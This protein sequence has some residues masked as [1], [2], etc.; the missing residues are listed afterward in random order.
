MTL[1]ADHEPGRGGEIVEFGRPPRPRWLGALALTCLVVAAITVLVTRTSSHH[2]ATSPPS[3][4]VTHVGHPILGVRAGWQLFGLGHGGLIRVQFASGQIT[5]TV[6]PAPQGDGIE[7]LLA[8]PGEALVRPLDNVTGYVVPDGK[9]ARP[10]SGAL[11]HGGILLPGPSSTQEWLA[12]QTIVLVGPNGRPEDA[13]LPGLTQA[14]QP[15][16][17]VAP[18]GRGGLLLP[19][20]SGA[21]YDVRSGLLRPVSALLLATGPRNWL[22]LSCDQQGS[23]QNVVISASTG[24]SRVLHGPA[25][26]VGTP[27]P[28][29][30]LPGSTAPNGSIAA[31]ITP[32]RVPGQ[33]WLDLINLKSGVAARVAVAVPA[34]SS[35]QSLAWSPDSRWLF[36]VTAHGTLAAVDAR[37]GRVRALGLGLSGLSEIVIRPAFG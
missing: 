14:A 32:G 2:H 27:W 30:S 20:A 19:V 26:V 13:R 16:Q 1:G 22:G 23:C 15:E 11:A 3:V 24:G 33:V 34:G 10:L 6:L 18:D 5:R 36:V 21:E 12:G 4:T 29:Q 7:S 8:P 9:P 25:V 17:P 37:T 35:S 28:W 31:V